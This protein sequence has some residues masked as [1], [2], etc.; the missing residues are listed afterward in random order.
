MALWTDVVTPLELTTVGRMSV[1]E[2]ERKRVSLSKF[3]PNRMVDD[4]VVRLTATSSGLVDTAEFRAYDAE[5]PI[6][7]VPGGKRVTVELPPLGQKVRVSEY[8]QLRMRNN[9]NNTVV[10]G[11]IGDVAK[12]VGASVSDRM[13]LLRGQVL[14]TG[15][16]TINEN[17]FVAEAD[18]GRDE[19]LNITVGTGWQDAAS[20]TPIEDL[21]AAVELYVNKTGEAP[22]TL[23][24][25]KKVIAAL[26]RCDEI[27]KTATGNTPTL[28]TQDY[29]SNLLAAFGLP[30]VELYDRM[31]RQG[32]KS[33]RVIDEKVALLLPE[34][35][36]ALGAT[37]WGKTLESQEANYAI[38]EDER[39]GIAVGAYKDDDPMGVWVKAAAIGMPILAD[40]NLSAALTVI[41][42]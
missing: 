27:R 26:M 29:V 15:K 23:L 19:D 42:G 38:A 39:P 31:V 20:A 14:V 4:S 25:S 21:Q 3:L 1:E 13:E 5:T 41:T 40:A 9:L 8:D 10:R 22:G 32:G 37:F 11:A 17:Q 7:A 24:L 28:V 34:D 18:F 16:A 36:S 2:R 30:K 35:G 12:Q 6:G 33:V